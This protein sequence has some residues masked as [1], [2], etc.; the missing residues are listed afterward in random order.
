MSGVI[1]YHVSSIQI[2]R[3]YRWQS[4]QFTF[5]N[6]IFQYLVSKVLVHTNPTIIRFKTKTW[7]GLVKLPERQGSFIKFIQLKE[8]NKLGNTYEGKHVITIEWLWSAAANWILPFVIADLNRT[9]RIE[10]G[11]F[12]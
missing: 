12:S 3:K 10:P 9:A 6:V 11:P 4:I 8:T 2:M 5:N 1:M 7:P